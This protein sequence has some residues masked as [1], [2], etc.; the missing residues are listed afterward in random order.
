MTDIRLLKE[1][2]KTHSLWGQTI[3]TTKETSKYVTSDHSRTSG[4][5]TLCM[6]DY[7]QNTIKLSVLKSDYWKPAENQTLR[8]QTTRQFKVKQYVCCLTFGK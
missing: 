2:C 8:R 4:K 3:E 1:Q 6:S 7:W 5:P